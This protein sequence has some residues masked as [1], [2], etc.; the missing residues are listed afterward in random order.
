MLVAVAPLVVALAAPALAV[1]LNAKVEPVWTSVLTAGQTTGR[2]TRTMELP[3]TST[4]TDARP[5]PSN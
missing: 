2:A 4:S 5:R 1:S 3:S